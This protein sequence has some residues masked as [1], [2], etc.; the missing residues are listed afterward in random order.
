MRLLCAIG[1][2][3]ALR[4]VH[5]CLIAD[6]TASRLGGGGPAAR[7]AHAFATR[8]GL[9][10]LRWRWD[11]LLLARVWLCARVRLCE[12]LIDWLVVRCGAM[13]AGVRGV[14]G[15]FFFKPSPMAESACTARRLSR[16]PVLLLACC[17]GDDIHHTYTATI[18][19]TSRPRYPRSLRRDVRY[20]PF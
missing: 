2:Q 9:L 7:T 10:P 17:N 8:A 13:R 5:G 11:G 15:P 1:R 19:I 6:F 16:A 12:D 3:I 14:G 20:V 18:T 4:L